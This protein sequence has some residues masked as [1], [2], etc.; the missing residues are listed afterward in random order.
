[1]EVL[2]WA[3]AMVAFVI[4]EAVTVQLV[5]IWF[6]IG[7]FISMLVAYFTEIS[8]VGQLGI[9][10]LSSAVMIIFTFPFLRKK[11]NSAHVG[12]NSELDVGKNATVIEEIDN[13]EGKGRVKLNGVDWSAVSADDNGVIAV[14]TVVTVVQVKGAKLYVTVNK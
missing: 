12:T 3:L 6:A 10:I 13:S 5:S 1:M 7:A 8:L 4:A 14:G 9:F 2:I 11:H